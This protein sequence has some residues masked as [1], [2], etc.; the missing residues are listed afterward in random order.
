[1]FLR[2]FD[3]AKDR[4]W[5]AESASS[6]NG[7]GKSVLGFVAIQHNPDRRGWAKLRWFLVEREARGLDFTHAV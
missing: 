3:P 6:G 4:I 5:L 1:M 7:S 2:N